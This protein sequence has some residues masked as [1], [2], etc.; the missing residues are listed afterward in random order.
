MLRKKYL[1]LDKLETRWLER[2]IH[3]L[4]LSHKIPVTIKKYVKAQTGTETWID[5]PLGESV[6]LRDFA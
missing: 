4:T 5:V 3:P 2:E 1:A 6:C